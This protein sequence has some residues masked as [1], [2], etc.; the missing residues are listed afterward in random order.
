MG[1]ILV[2]LFTKRPPEKSKSIFEGSGEHR[3]L[4]LTRFDHFRQEFPLPLIMT[5]THVWPIPKKSVGLT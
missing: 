2:N 1:V 5:D 3:S 4:V